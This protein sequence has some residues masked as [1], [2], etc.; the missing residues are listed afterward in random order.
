MTVAEKHPLPSE[1]PQSQR[2]RPSSFYDVEEIIKDELT[3]AYIGSPIL[4]PTLQSLDSFQQQD[5]TLQ[6]MDDILHYLPKNVLNGMSAE[7][8]LRDIQYNY[9]LGKG[10]V[11]HGSDLGRISER[12]FYTHHNNP[13]RLFEAI[14]NYVTLRLAQ[15]NLFHAP[16]GYIF[17]LEENYV[18]NRAD[19]DITQEKV[20]EEIDTFIEDL[21]ADLHSHNA[22]KRIQYARGISDND[23]RD[24]FS[25]ERAP[26]TCKIT[27]D[28][29]PERKRKQLIHI[30]EV[31]IA[32][33]DDA[34]LE[35]LADPRSNKKQ[36]H[37]DKISHRLQ[38]FITISTEHLFGE[39]R[40]YLDDW[41]IGIDTEE[42]AS[43]HIRTTSDFSDHIEAVI[44]QIAEDRKFTPDEITTLRGD[45]LS[46]TGGHTWIGLR[47]ALEDKVIDTRIREVLERVYDE[48]VNNPEFVDLILRHAIKIRLFLKELGVSIND[49]AAVT[50]LPSFDDMESNLRSIAANPAWREQLYEAYREED[51]ELG[52]E[53]KPTL[54]YWMTRASGLRYARKERGM[55]DLT[56]D[57]LEIALDKK[58]TRAQ[59]HAIALVPYLAEI[60]ERFYFPK[61]VAADLRGISM[62]WSRRTRTGEIRPHPLV[63]VLNPHISEE[64]LETVLVQQGAKHMLIDVYDQISR[65]KQITPPTIAIIE[66]FIGMFR[67]QAEVV[68]AARLQ[69]QVETSENLTLERP[70][71]LLEL[72]KTQ[73]F[74]FQGTVQLEL[75]KLVEIYGEGLQAND[76]G[77]E[78]FLAI[79]AEKAEITDSSLQDAPATFPL[80]KYL[81]EKAEEISGAMMPIY[82]GRLAVTNALNTN[83]IFSSLYRRIEIL[84]SSEDGEIINSEQQSNTFALTSFLQQTFGD[85]WVTNQDARIFALHI[86]LNAANDLQLLNDISYI[87]REYKD[88]K[89]IKQQFIR[90]GININKL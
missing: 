37:M 70:S 81:E 76:E 48:R 6:T 23:A 57:E 21:L 22:V 28:E 11:P 31:I 56:P 72:L 24:F 88:I 65:R 66:A 79:L 73:E 8:K 69:Q 77:V 46:I 2:E 85:V 51:P 53:S 54:P 59:E 25:G 4:H 58:I 90:N 1:R 16:D 44:L 49:Y 20:T 7:D 15:N 47:T 34:L 33:Y 35:A 45:V 74:V 61:S 83:D 86:A 50:G 29:N 36:E 42:R 3:Q 38:R 17:G 89:N 55:Q 18:S 75:S 13:D 60:G 9:L 71:K 62:Q 41:L 87:T 82:G 30:G 32:E 40:K 43:G 64:L 84:Q 52:A 67:Q 39:E 63:S 80:F 78:E 12:I 10:E 14:D 5:P 19:Y 68:R 27:L 26:Y